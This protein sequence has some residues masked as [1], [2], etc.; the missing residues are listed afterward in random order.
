[1]AEKLRIL[2]ADNHSSVRVNLAAALKLDPGLDVVGEASDGRMAVEL[3]RRL[4]PDIVIMDIKMPALNGIE[5]TRL[6][7]SDHPGIIVI[8]LSFHS[9]HSLGVEM[10]KAGASACIGK[11]EPIQVLMAAIHAC[12]S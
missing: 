6:I 8:G 3:T 5:A 11:G 9:D 12:R 2:L 10:R 4:L 1:M 7:V